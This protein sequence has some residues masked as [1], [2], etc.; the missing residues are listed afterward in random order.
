MNNLISTATK[1]K[2]FYPLLLL[3]LLPYV[4]SRINSQTRE[5]SVSP[6]P[7]PPPA[8]VIKTDIDLVTVDALVLQKKTA[9]VVGNL[10]EADF[11]I[12]EDGSKQQ[13][14]QD[15]TYTLFLTTCLSNLI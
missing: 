6:N 10:K 1:Y 9:R 2:Y 13:L 12:L 3:A 11:V 14:T 15:D 8:E 7:A 4:S 5:R